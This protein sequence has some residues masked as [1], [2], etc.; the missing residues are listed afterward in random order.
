LIKSLRHRNTL[1]PFSAVAVA[2][3]AY[4]LA[5]IAIERY[6][7]ICRPLHSRL[8]QTKGHAAVM[9]SLVWTISLLSNVGALFMFE[10]PPLQP[11]NCGHA[12]YSQ[13][14]HFVYQVYITTV[15]L[16][17]PLVLMVAL[18]GYVIHT[19]KLGMRIDFAGVVSSTNGQ[20]DGSI[21]HP[22]GNS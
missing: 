14:T 15:L 13:L 22:P 7:A 21:L 16:V 2:A 3:S 9:I 10:S 12:P 20:I 8:W 11:M 1:S 5:V 19:L 4:T 6:Y 17:I 18:Y